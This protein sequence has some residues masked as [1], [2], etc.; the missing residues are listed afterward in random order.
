MAKIK[1]RRAIQRDDKRDPR[2]IQQTSL[3]SSDYAPRAKPNYKIDP[4]TENQ[5]Q[6]IGAIYDKDITIALAPA[7]CGKTFIGGGLAA[8]FLAEGM[9]EKIV[10]TRA[11]VGVGQSIGMLPGTIQEKM[12]PLLAPILSV[13]K[14]RMGPGAYEYNLNKEKIVMQPLEYVRGLSFAETF[15]IVDEAQNL[16][17]D[18]VI[19]IYTRFESGRV[20]FIGDICQ[21]DIVGENG[22]SWLAKFSAR[23]NLDVGYVE[24]GLEDIVRSGAVKQFLTALYTERGWV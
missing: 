6:L 16:T 4:K 11:N 9:V 5:R 14:Q 2:G 12:A 7:G 3:T 10:L 23:H 21:T 13:L 15:L 1:T 19:A 17:I 22:L 18:D 24:F 20:L 8:K